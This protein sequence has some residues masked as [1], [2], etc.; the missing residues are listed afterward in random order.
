[1]VASYSIRVAGSLLEG[2]TTAIHDSFSPAAFLDFGNVFGTPNLN[3][4]AN[5]NL[6]APYSAGILGR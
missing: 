5:G 4:G 2:S 3:V 6:V 1:L